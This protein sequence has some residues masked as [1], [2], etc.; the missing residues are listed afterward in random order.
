[1]TPS[2]A[3]SKL[4]EDSGLLFF[5]YDLTTSRFL[6]LNPA[7][8]DFFNVP[9]DVA[10]ATLLEMVHPEDHNYLSAKLQ[11]YLDEKG[12]QPVECRIIRGDHERWLRIH[13]RLLKENEGT[14]LMGHAEDFTYGKEF[15]NNLTRH[16]NEKNSILNI[17]A[18]DLAGPIGTV[19][20]LSELLKR[21][22][23][24]LNNQR[25]NEYIEM[26]RKITKSS[27]SL[28]RDY[29]NKEFLESK[30]VK[31]LKSRIE[32]VGKI[33]SVTH[34]Y[35]DMQKVMKI[36]FF[37]RANREVIYIE[38]DEDKFM[39][40]INNLISNALKFTPEGGSITVNVEESDR[41]VLISV[42]DTGIGIP[43]KYHATLFDKFSQARRTG[44]KGQHSTGLGMSIIKTIVD[45]HQGKIWFN[46]EENNGTT[47][48]VELPK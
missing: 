11:E 31:L 16:N 24:A 47:F 45:W 39:Q 46:S 34:E 15:M 17:I 13:P 10:P 27:I 44:L 29:V 42:A 8:K 1:M 28:I 6:Y 30:G 35:L 19:G 21:E 43:K 33:N 32:L 2:A 12:A 40:V 23:A 9:D 41:S 3:L 36:Q 48:Y 38:L 18:H 7:F 4:A 14:W 22:T 20:N 5:S 26:M 37:C 25:V